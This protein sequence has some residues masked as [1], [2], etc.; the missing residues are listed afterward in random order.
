[1]YILFLFKPLNL[2]YLF[3]IISQSY[4]L[5]T[6]NI[7]QYYLIFSWNKFFVLIPT[8]D[9]LCIVKKLFYCYSWWISSHSLW[10]ASHNMIQKSWTKVNS[11][12]SQ[13]HYK[14]VTINVQVKISL[15]NAL[16]SICNWNWP[17]QYVTIDV[18]LKIDLYDT[19]KSMCKWKWAF[20]I[21]Y[22]PHTSWSAFNSSRNKNTV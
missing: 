19:L 10:Y 15:N 11:I 20:M 7:G 9:I 3:I 2:G 12:W 5:F 18:Q 8:L 1:M 6:H 14:Y 16:Q 22:V 4:S 21:H 17:W 13:L